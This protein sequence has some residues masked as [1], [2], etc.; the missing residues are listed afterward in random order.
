MKPLPLLPGLVVL[1]A[2]RLA[3]AQGPKCELAILNE[4]I[5]DQFVPTG[6]EVDAIYG[7]FVLRNDKM[8]V[9]IANP[10]AGRNANMT[11][12]DVGGAIIDLTT[13]DRQS[14]QLS[15]YYRVRGVTRIDLRES[16][17]R[18]ASA[19]MYRSRR[20]RIKLQSSLAR[21]NWNRVLG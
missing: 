5:W 13:R 17:L 7:D 6:K 9:V 2:S 11:V 18:E 14:D 16:P 10:V 4:K 12:K 3:F 1:L 21:A 19:S 8:I 15:A 20:T